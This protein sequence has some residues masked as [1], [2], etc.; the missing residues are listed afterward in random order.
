MQFNISAIRLKFQDAYNNRHY[1]VAIELGESI[2]NAHNINNNTDNPEYANDLLYLASAYDKVGHHDIS[3]PMYK[4]VINVYLDA[5]GE[6]E[7]LAE[8]ISFLAKS[9][10]LKGDHDTA[11]ALHIKSYN[12]KTSLSV[13]GKSLFL[14]NYNLANGYVDTKRYTDFERYSCAIKHLKKALLLCEQNSMDHFDVLNSMCFLHENK[15]EFTLAIDY[16]KQATGIIKTLKDDDPIYM[17][18]Q[19]YYLGLLYEKNKDYQKAFSSFKKSYKLLLDNKKTSNYQTTLILNKLVDIS[20]T[21][22]EFK[23]AIT[24]RTKAIK[25]N[26][27]LV[28]N[29]H[30]TAIKDMKQLAKLQYNHG[31]KSTAAE[32]HLK[33][34]RLSSEI[35]GIESK[36]YYYEILDTFSLL[37]KDNE[38]QN[39]SLLF[40]EITK[41]VSSY[42]N[43]LNIDK[44]NMIEK[45]N[46]D[47]DIH[48][49]IDEFKEICLE[50]KSGKSIWRKF[51][52]FFN[53]YVLSKQL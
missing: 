4:K 41:S 2:I 30:I 40:I 5:Y 19:N 50:Q 45:T 33:V 13:E 29:I 12:I 31:T 51:S 8:Y 39:A 35:F 22:E 16:L 11:I 18:K 6:T 23:K 15:E 28:G 20:I 24:Y 32:L 21:L 14:A 53:E 27:N 34:I 36:E 1:K 49:S 10:N 25:V 7:E 48:Q 52:D 37:F 26:Y 17:V 46:V 3:I 43:P 9:Y 42:S 47:N 38:L 44:D